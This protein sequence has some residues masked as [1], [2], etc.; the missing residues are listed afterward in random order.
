MC[1]VYIMRF[2]GLRGSYNSTLFGSRLL[3][4]CPNIRV[5]VVV[6]WDV[7]GRGKIL[8]GGVGWMWTRVGEV[9]WLVEISGKNWVLNIRIRFC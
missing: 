8:R 4:Y 1:A 2:I 5:T 6:G 7:Q 9:W 3:A